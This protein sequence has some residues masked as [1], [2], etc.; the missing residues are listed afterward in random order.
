MPP[1]A[2]HPEAKPMQIALAGGNGFIGRELTAQL[3]AGGHEVVWLSHRP[4]ATALP[5]GVRE[6]AFTPAEKAT[7]WSG[8]VVAADAVANLSGFPIASRWNARTRPLLRT[9][10]LDTTRALVGVI[11]AA[12]AQG[13]GPRALVGGSAVGIYGDRGELVLA[14]D[15]R[16]GG[17]FLAD[18]AVDWE[19]AALAAENAGCRVATIRTGIVL[20]AE[21]VL[22]RMELPSRF[23]LGGPIGSGKQWVSWVHVADI[24]GLYRH[25]LESDAVTGPL[26]AGAP[27]PVRMRELSSALGRRLGRPSWFPVP[28]FALGLV[29]GEVAPYTVMSQ[30][31]SADH[32]I[33][34]GYRFRFPDIDSALTDLVR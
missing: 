26:N 27:E 32:A 30:R 16:T 29:L 24:A 33:E 9:S 34:T 31:M 17:D 10:R 20:G 5:D 12:R 28:G 3:L 21:G 14:E 7:A 8:E 19:A 23:F 6:V 18:L 2:T 1:R 11:E 4:G 25:A 22:P 13:G 15:A